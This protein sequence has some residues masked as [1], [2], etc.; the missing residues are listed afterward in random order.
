MLEMK[1]CCRVP[2]PEMLFEEYEAGENVIYANINA[3]RVIEMMKRFIE[4]HDEPMFFILELPCKYE[5]GITQSKTLVN[6]G[7]NNDVY[8]I[9][10]MDARQAE[11]V[12]DALGGFLVKDGMNT[13]GI[14]CHRSHEE[15]LLGK[16]N[17]MTVYTRDL[18]KYAAFF[19]SFGIKRTDS[20]VTAWN[21]F[22]PE[23]PGECTRYV[24]KETGRT[25]YDIPEIYKEYGM[26]LYEQRSED[27]E[28]YDKEV[29]FDELPGKILLV[30]ITY[31]T[32]DKELIEQKQFYGRVSEANE[33]VIRII[34]KD[35]TEFTLPPDLSSTRRA[36]PGEYTLRATGEV[37][38]DPDFIAEWDLTKAEGKE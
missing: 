34:Q 4:I 1:E 5:D 11:Q 20:L 26:Y 8:F 33:R 38:I 16:Y 6:L 2:F 37:V 14:G 19:D 15:I 17:V 31:Y 32:H 23:H 29:E 18:D 22:D 3:S 28:L 27:G 7:E 21:T 35:G 30:G 10:G 12:L 24:S 25:V 13:F 36:R 9:D